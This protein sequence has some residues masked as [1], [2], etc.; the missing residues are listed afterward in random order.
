[1]NNYMI[2]DPVE[3]IQ[4]FYKTQAATLGKPVKLV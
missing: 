1:M 4:T 3:F 2:E